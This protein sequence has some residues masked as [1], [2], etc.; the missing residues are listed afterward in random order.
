[1]HCLQGLAIAMFLCAI[2]ANL[3]YGFGII[4][5]AYSWDIIVG[6]APWILGSLGTVGLDF[7]IYWQVG[8]TSKQLHVPEMHKS[9]VQ[10]VK[11]PCTCPSKQ[12]C[13]TS[14]F[15]CMVHCVVTGHPFWTALQLSH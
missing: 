6:S 10:S 14:L 13:C 2:A 15:K 3:L 5:R 12:F 1:M 8:A 11:A 9:H 7:V 4:I